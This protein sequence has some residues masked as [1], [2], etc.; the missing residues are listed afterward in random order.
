M[1]GDPGTFNVQTGAT[2]AA[3][4]INP[5]SRGQVLWTK[6]YPAPADNITRMIGPVDAVNRVFTMVDKETMKWSG[7]SLDTGAL[8]WGPVGDFRGYQYYSSNIAS[9]N[10]GSYAVA[11]GKLFVCGFGGVVYAFD[12]KNGNQL[13]SYGNGGEETPQTTMEKQLG[14]TDQLS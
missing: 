12:T 11:Y 14:E 3:I 10:A 8:L 2:I 13:W 1:Q 4:S 7:Y 6:F 9:Y 5:S